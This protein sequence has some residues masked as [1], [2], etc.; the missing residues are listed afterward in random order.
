MG[1]GTK[2]V[3]DGEVGPVCDRLRFYSA[4][5]G[6][7]TENF[8]HESVLVRLSFGKMEVHVPIGRTSSFLHKS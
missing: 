8:K 2:E 5:D 3:D 4:G 6:G 1:K 7:A